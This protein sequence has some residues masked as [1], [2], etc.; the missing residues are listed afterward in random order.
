MTETTHL[1]PFDDHLAARLLHQRIVLVGAEIDDVVA[2]RVTAQLLLLSA[3]DTS[4]DI[5]LYLNSPGGSIE[6]G[7]AVLDTM[8]LVPNDVS[9]VAVGFAGG[10][11]QFLLTAGTRGK[12]YA[13][14]HAR[15]VLHQP[16]GGVGGATSDVVVQAEHARH[17][18]DVMTRLQAEHTGQSV[19]TVSA[20]SERDRWFTAEQALAYGMVDRIV[21]RTDDVRPGGKRRAG[22]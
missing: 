15:V 13:L 12:R 1:Q 16:P 7:L 8:R 2:S 21:D 20:D 3:E 11:A 9:T 19:E 17:L 4:A 6:A 14:P 18:K 10:T 22:L 5:S